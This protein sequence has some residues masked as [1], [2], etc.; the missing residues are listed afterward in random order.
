M[1]ISFSGKET[2]NAP[3]QKV[4]DFVSNPDKVA[5]CIPDSSEFKRLGERSFTIKVSVGVGTIKGT[6]SISGSFEIPGENQFTYNLNGAGF[7]NKVSIKLSVALEPLGS[8]T[9]LDWNA[10]FDLSGIISGLGAGIIRKVSE[11]KIGIIISN[12]KKALESET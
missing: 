6:F 5:S 11:E 3:I 12:V 9:L 2:V 1:K 10:E 7:G 4:S 8:T